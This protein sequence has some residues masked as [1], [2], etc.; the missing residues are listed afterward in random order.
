MTEDAR[1]DAIADLLFAASI[2]RG[3][4]RSALAAMIEIAAHT[5]ATDAER[6]AHNLHP[7]DR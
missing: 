3:E 6:S 5:L 4:Q 2:L 7:E 1:A